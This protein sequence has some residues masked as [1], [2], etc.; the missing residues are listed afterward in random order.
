[1]RWRLSDPPRPA[2]R[3]R[4]RGPAPRS[5]RPAHRGAWRRN[6]GRRSCK[7]PRMRKRERCRVGHGTGG[8]GQILVDGSRAAARAVASAPFSAGKR[9]MLC[10]LAGRPGIEFAPLVG[11]GFKDV[12]LGK[13]AV[14]LPFE[15]MQEERELDVLAVIERRSWNRTARCPRGRHRRARSRHGSTDPS[16]ACWWRAGCWPGSPGRCA[17]GPTGSSASYQPPTV[18]TAGLMFF[19]YF[20]MERDCQK[21]LYEVL[22][23]DLRPER[24][25]VFEV[26]SHRRWPASPYP[27]RTGSHPAY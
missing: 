24:I 5:C 7:S 3:P 8:V 10:A 19:R 14:A 4:R 9:S 12:G 23:D 6:A 11:A 27:E 22:H 16:P 25:G 15:G 1:M 2:R 13:L 21:L 20:Q 17:A 18:I 26:A